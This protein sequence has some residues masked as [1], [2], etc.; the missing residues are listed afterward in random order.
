MPD[1]PTSVLTKGHSGEPVPFA[2]TGE[3]IENKMHLPLGETNAIKTGIVFNNGYE[4]MEFF[5]KK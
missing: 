5:L 4:L 1:H 2:M 3:G